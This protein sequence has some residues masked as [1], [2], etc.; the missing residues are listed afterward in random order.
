MTLATRLSITTLTTAVTRAGLIPSAAVI[1]KVIEMRLWAVQLYRLIARTLTELF[2]STEIEL[3]STHGF[4]APR[5][6][7]QLFGGVILKVFKAET[8]GTQHVTSF[9]SLNPIH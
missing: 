5:S 2:G 6:S 3:G 4:D 9:Q 7:R 8:I 1:L